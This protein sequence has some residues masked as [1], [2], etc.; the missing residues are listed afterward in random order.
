MRLFGTRGSKQPIHRDLLLVELDTTA[1]QKL[2]IQ[3]YKKLN[4]SVY[5]SGDKT[6]SERILE[7]KFRAEINRRNSALP[8]AIDGSEGRLR[9]SVYVIVNLQTQ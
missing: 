7:S 9:Y 8:N 1:N 5:I 4:K 6:E 2:V 3:N